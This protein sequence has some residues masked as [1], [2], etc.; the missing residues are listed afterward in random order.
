MTRVARLLVTCLAAAMFTGCLLP[1]GPKVIVDRR[2]GE[3][4]SGDGILVDRS[5][6]GSQCRVAIRSE[7][8]FVERR[9]IPCKYVHE[10]FTP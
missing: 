2:G 3:S 4:W 10:S 6:D 7:A 8:L 9:W 5:A 1:K